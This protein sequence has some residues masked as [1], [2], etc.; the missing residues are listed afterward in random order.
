MAWGDVDGDGDDDLLLGGAAGS[1][2]QLY[3]NEGGQLGHQVV[4]AFDQDQDA[5]D[6][7][8]LFF[9]ADG[10]H[11]LDLYVVS[12]GVE[13]EPNSPILRDRLYMNDGAG[14]FV[15]ADSSTLPDMQ[16]S[17]G[18]V[19]AADYDRDGDLDLFVGGR[20]VPGR[21]PETPRNQLLRN[22]GKGTFADATSEELGSTG[23]VTSALWSDVDSDGWVDLLM[24]HEWGPVKIFTNRAG[25]LTEV[26]VPE[27]DERTGWWNSIAGADVDGDGDMD[28]AVG[29]VGLNTKYEASSDHPTLLYYGDLDGSGRPHIVEAGFEGATQ[30]PVRGK[31]CSSGAMPALS[32]RFSTF[33]SFAAASLED[34]YGSAR[35]R[36]AQQLSANTLE[37]GVM[38]NQTKPGGVVRFEFR[39]LPRI[40]QVSPVYGLA[41][42]H[43]NDDATPDLYVVQN[44]FGPQRETGRMDGGVS[45]LLEGVGDGSFIPIWPDTSGLVVPGDGASVTFSDIDRDGR[46]DLFVGINDGQQL[47]FRNKAAV[48][49]N[50][51]LIGN[52]GNPTAIGSRVTVVMKGGEKRIA[53]VQAGG[54]YLSQSSPI[55]SFGLGSRGWEAVDQ[56]QIRWPYGEDTEHSPAQGTHK[57]GVMWIERRE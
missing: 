21:Y 3:L 1:S 4:P 49:G 37:S 28:Y 54:G 50:V 38:L 51:R 53:E 46:L 26:S 14:G 30:F 16:V 5:E 43:I 34:I 15:R 47:A 17:G 41:F 2:A 29:N 11:D 32:S 10:D 6:M 9:D 56:L 45:V 57:D 44:F 7:A 36:Q 27:I 8:P 25:K 48:T 23:L 13:C 18:V 42:M 39:P 40:A 19:C 33:H 52:A 20:I 55:L 31:S 22:N 12:G 35:L 24:T